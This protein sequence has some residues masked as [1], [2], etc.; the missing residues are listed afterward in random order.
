MTPEEPTPEV[1]ALWP[2]YLD[3]D[4]RGLVA[5]VLALDEAERR[6]PRVPSGWTPIELLSHVLHM[7]QRW[8]VWIFLGE[9]VADPWGDWTARDPWTGDDTTDP[10]ARWHVP[11]GTTAEELAERLERLGRRTTEILAAHPMQAPATPAA[12]WDGTPPTLEWICFHVLQ[13]YARHAGH[14]DI[15]A[16][17]ARQNPVMP[18][19]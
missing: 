14:L 1:A 13:E 7:E 8:F 17:L 9:P 6:V 11:E 18:S 2:A 19:P 10:A 5:A 4:R 12:G 15:V 16:E 3:F